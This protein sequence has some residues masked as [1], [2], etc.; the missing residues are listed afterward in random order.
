M[1]SPQKFAIYIEPSSKPIEIQSL[2]HT[3]VVKDMVPDLTNFYNQYKSIEPWLKRKDVKA[4]G[5]AEYFQS[6]GDVVPDLTNFYNQYKSIE[7]WLKRKDVK[8]KGDAEYFQSWEEVP[9]RRAFVDFQRWSGRYFEKQE[10]AKCGKHAVNNLLGMPQFLDE[11]LART[12]ADLCAETGEPLF[13]HISARGWYSIDVMTRLFDITAPPLGRVLL[14][15][16]V[17][18]D[19]RCLMETDLY[20]GILVNHNGRHWVCILRH[21]GFLWYVDSVYMPRSITHDEFQEILLMYPRSY[22]VEKH[23]RA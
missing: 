20:Y 2:P 15:P 5:N 4:K 3:Y 9:D 22:L 1:A 21:N 6:R 7:P 10:M 8:A 23:S 17:P 18:G 16:C 19:Y 12:A 11:D 14:R 13:R